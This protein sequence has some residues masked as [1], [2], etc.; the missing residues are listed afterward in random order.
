MSGITIDSIE[1]HRKVQRI[2]INMERWRNESASLK[3]IYTWINIPSYMFYVVESNAVV[4]E[5]RVVVGAPRTPTP[6]LSSNIECFTLFPYWY[7]PRKIAVKEYL[8]AI[9][10]DTSFV[11]RNNFDVLDQDGNI[12]ILSSIDW[13]KY[14]ANNFPFRFRQREGLENSLGIIKFVFDNPYAVYVH[15]TNSKRLF[16]C[17]TRAFSHG[18]IRL[19]KAIEFSYYLIGGK[20]TNLTLQTLNKYISQQK[21]I[22]VSLAPAVPIYIR[23]FTC[24]V[25]Q[26]VL[27]FYDDIYQKDQPL[28]NAIY[29]LPQRIPL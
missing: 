19:E 5:S 15:D 13:K 6:Q 24:E 10:K 28:I 14:N 16:R 27:R 2:E 17:K 8:P 7:V 26:N 21:G 22:T 9:K 29:S 20:R 12:Q 3:D 25:N 11:T 1:L 4:M 23:Y 18:C